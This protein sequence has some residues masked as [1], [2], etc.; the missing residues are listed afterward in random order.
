MLTPGELQALARRSPRLRLLDV[1]TPGEH[2]AVHIPGSYN[3]PI[4]A[5]EAHLPAM[6]AGV[7]GPV[8]LICHSGQRAR[9]AAGM[10]AAAALPDALVLEGGIV[11][12]AAEGGSVVRAHPRLPLERQVRIAAGLLAAMGAALALLVHPLFALVPLFIGSGLTFAGITNRCGLALVLTRLPYNR[13][14]SVDVPAV[15]RA[16]VQGAPPPAPTHVA[17]TGEAWASCT[18]G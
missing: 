8:V 10:L 16:L 11:R 1:R 12:W 13:P 6:R 4:D 2:E 14:A 18:T 15:V 7:R 9:R 17:G 3:V 5:L